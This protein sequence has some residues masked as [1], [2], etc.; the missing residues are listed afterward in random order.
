MGAQDFGL[1][2]KSIRWGDFLGPS[3]VIINIRAQN[4]APGFWLKGKSN[5]WGDFWGPLKSSNQYKGP[6]E[7]PHPHPTPLHSE[8]AHS[9]ERDW[10]EREW[11]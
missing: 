10:T 1:K 4:L 11:D 6:F 9:P 5:R 7:S 3:K 2:G 8:I